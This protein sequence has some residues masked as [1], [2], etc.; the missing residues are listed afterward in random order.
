MLL[1]IIYKYK[2]L[3]NKIPDVLIYLPLTHLI[4]LIKNNM[5]YL[6]EVW[7]WC[8][9]PNNTSDLCAFFL[10]G[11][12]FTMYAIELHKLLTAKYPENID[13]MFKCLARNSQTHPL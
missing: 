2:K 6:S 12:V 8:G 7:K 11:G 10:W 9:F 3:K 13:E 5:Y 4:I 1:N